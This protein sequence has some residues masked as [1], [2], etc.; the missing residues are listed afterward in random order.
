M[1]EQLVWKHMQLVIGFVSHHEDH[2][3]AY[4]REKMQMVSE[5]AIKAHRKKL[6]QYE[7]RLAELDRLFMR[8]Y[9]DNVA[10]KI[11]D[12]RYIAMSTAYESEQAT[13]K[14]E[15]AALQQEIDAQSSQM[16]GL[17]HFIQTIHR[18]DELDHL[19]P[20]AARELIHA[21]RVS[22]AEKINGKRHQE[23]R[24]EYDIVGF[25]PINELLK[26][27]QVA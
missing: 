9:E 13:L 24:I 17:E 1:L 20:C 6:T 5:E 26:A 15:I 19:T 23:I 7:N 2:F 4:M 14:A 12:E 10:G 11:S 21:V 16:E 25:I 8:L 27:A 18:Y 22:K 3:R